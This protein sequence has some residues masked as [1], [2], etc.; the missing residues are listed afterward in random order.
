[1]LAQT[2]TTNSF[3]H[4]LLY[5]NDGGATISSMR[6]RHYYFLLPQLA[7][8]KLAL[9]ICKIEHLL[10]LASLSRSFSI[11]FLIN[12]ECCIRCAYVLLQIACTT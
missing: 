3:L 9:T 11:S 7:P 5:I 1:M 6:S 10:L 2:I 8:N 4:C 12:T